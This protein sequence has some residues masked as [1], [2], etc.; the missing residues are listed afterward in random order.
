MNE[1]YIPPGKDGFKGQ[2]LDELLALGYFR[3]DDQLFTST[4]APDEYYGNSILYMNIYWL[5]TLVDH[6][7][8]SRA[9]RNI[10]NKCAAFIT[11]IRKAEIT[12]EVKALY[13]LYRDHVPFLLSEFGYES[14][15]YGAERFPFD[16]WMVEV[17]DNDTLV[18]AG[19]FDLG[20]KA[21]MG[22]QNMYHPLYQK[23]SL[24]KFLM[25]Q[26]MDYT[27][28]NQM[29]YYYTGY[30]STSKTCF[31]YKLFPD[32]SAVE[33]FLPVEKVWKPY[34][35]YSKSMLDEYFEVNYLDPL[36]L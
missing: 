14:F 35:T 17:R 8:E 7:R 23:Y 5:R 32:P 28:L 16:S 18:A 36:F 13:A 21:I 4:N 24:G 19:F 3:M 34:N 22:I 11:T 29:D 9:A 31:D 26:K 20:A 27:R 12:D 2:M 1:H 25:L 33:V 15:D 6:V 30:I 10:R